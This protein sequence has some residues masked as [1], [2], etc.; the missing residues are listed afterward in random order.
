[1]RVHVIQTGSVVANKTLM[2]GQGWSSLLRRREDYRFPS[3]SFILE[4]PEGLIAIDTGLTARVRIPRFQHRM[5]PRPI[6]AS[7]EEE[8]GPRMRA[9][10]LDPGEVRRVVLTHLD[11]D[12][13]GGLAHFPNAE[14]LVHRPE[15]EFAS[16]LA[17]KLRYQPKLW[18]SEFEPTV[19]DLEPDPH[20]P[21]PESKPITNGGD[22][23]VVPIPGHSI[24]QVGVLVQTDGPPLL[25]AADHVLRQDWFV[26]DYRDG[27]LLGLAF[28]PKL[29]VE[30][31]RRIHQL[32]EETPTVFLPSHDTETPSRLEAMEPLR[33]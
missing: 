9:I 30:T 25:F 13:A 17:G 22:V 28:Y 21:F 6:I 8:I 14:F 33:L 2:R 31:S 5:I 23:R 32:V 20:G 24:G 19:Y 10:G 11:W 4:H 16:K 7:E 27:N 3:Y 29:A 15:Y 18:P 1:M 26:E 12:H